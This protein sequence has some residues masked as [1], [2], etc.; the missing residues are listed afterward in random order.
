MTMYHHIRII[1]TGIGTLDGTTTT[2]IQAADGQMGSSGVIN[3]G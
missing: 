3:N 2:I 1:T